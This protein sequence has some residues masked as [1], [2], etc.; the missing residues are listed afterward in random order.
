[1]PIHRFAA[2]ALVAALFMTLIQSLT[3]AG[4]SNGVSSSALAAQDSQLKFVGAASCS[5][6]KCHGGTEAGKKSAY[7]VWMSKDKHAKS[8]NVLFEQDSKDIANALKIAAADTSERCLSCHSNQTPE[9]RRGEKFDI[10]DGNT[11]EQCHGPAEKWIDIHSEEGWTREKSVG[12]G[13]IDSRDM[14]IRAD[15]CIP[16]HVGIDADML[17]AGHPYPAFEFDSFLATMPPHWEDEK[18]WAAVRAWAVGQAVSLRDSLQWVAKRAGPEKASDE[19]L[20]EM[21]SETL[22][23]HLALK[24][25]AAAADGGKAAALDAGMAN[26]RKAIES[27]DR[28]KLASAETL[29]ATA[30]SLGKAL[31]TLSLEAATTRK[32]LAG[33]AAAGPGLGGESIQAAEQIALS[34]DSLSKALEANGVVLAGM[35]NA[36]NGLFDQL[37]EDPA[38]FDSATFVKALDAVAAAAK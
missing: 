21:W 8:Y 20:K 18:D 32:F 17:D 25:A 3:P 5:A 30:D 9:T 24:G 10:A 2:L 16:C 37:P 19:M 35:E 12:M 27:G 36:V 29:A 14:Y 38:A 22:G 31:N 1:M 23:R 6:A 34:V 11:W 7:T 15:T 33:S 28:A 26:L 13:A 4:G